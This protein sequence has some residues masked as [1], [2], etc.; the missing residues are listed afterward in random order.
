MHGVDNARMLAAKDDERSGLKSS[1]LD[2]DAGFYCLDNVFQG[3]MKIFMTTD[4]HTY[5]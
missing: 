2:R 3:S 5:N 1:V 4:R